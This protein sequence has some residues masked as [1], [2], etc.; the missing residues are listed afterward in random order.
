MVHL[1]A[2]KQKVAVLLQERVD[3]EGEVVEVGC[4]HGRLGV[5]RRL[6]RGQ[7]RGE[8]GGSRLSGSL[9]LV[10][11]GGDQVRVVDFNG[12]L[13]QDVLVPEVG[14]LEPAKNN[15]LACVYHPSGAIVL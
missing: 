14:L 11:E 15:Q 1:D 10:N 7:G 12:E 8:I 3:A 4:Q 5:L 6:Q 9:E 2:V 13:D